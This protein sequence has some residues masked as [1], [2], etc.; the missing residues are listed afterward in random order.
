MGNRKMLGK[1]SV[2]VG[3][4]FASNAID[5]LAFGDVYTLD[6]CPVSLELAKPTIGR[7]VAALR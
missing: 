4:V 6:T 7:V 2:V 1:V 5:G 3:L